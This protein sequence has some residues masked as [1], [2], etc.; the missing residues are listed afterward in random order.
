[1]HPDS[2]GDLLPL[3]HG[4]HRWYFYDKLLLVLSKNRRTNDKLCEFGAISFE[5]VA[6]NCCYFSR[7]FLHNYV[8]SSVSG[9][10]LS[11]LCNLLKN[12]LAKHKSSNQTSDS[13][14]I[15]F[16]KDLHIRYITAPSIKSFR[17]LEKMIAGSF[18]GTAWLLMTVIFL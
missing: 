13:S 11:C 8:D 7:S 15:C 10:N 12:R 17:W 18:E 1:M 14:F 2:W 9:N 3:P 4:C 5:N 16:D 6:L